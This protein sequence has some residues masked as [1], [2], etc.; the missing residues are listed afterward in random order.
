[1]TRPTALQALQAFPRIDGNTLDPAS[2][3]RIIAIAA[4]I[5][6]GLQRAPSSLGKRGRRRHWPPVPALS[7]NDARQRAVYQSERS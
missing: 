1:M 2:S 5:D 4:T 7:P 3:V 6:N